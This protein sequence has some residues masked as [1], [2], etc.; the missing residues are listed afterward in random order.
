LGSSFAKWVHDGVSNRSDRLRMS[1]DVRYQLVSEPSNI[2]NTDPDGQPPAWEEVYEDWQSDALK[3]YW[4]RLWFDKRDAL[5]FELGEA[6]DPRASTMPWRI[7]ARYTR[8]EER[9]HARKLL[10]TLP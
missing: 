1:T 9:A 5:G 10:G 4:R 3:Y 8:A 7:V 6:G 2:D